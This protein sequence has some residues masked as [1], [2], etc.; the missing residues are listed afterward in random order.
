MHSGGAGALVGPHLRS[1]AGP[2]IGEAPAE[3]GERQGEHHDPERLMEGEGIVV[4]GIVI[5]QADH[6][7]PE[8][9]KADDPERDGPVEADGDKAVSVFSVLPHVRFPGRRNADRPYLRMPSTERKKV[10]G[11]GRPTQVHARAEGPAVES[12]AVPSKPAR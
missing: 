11:F 7:D 5:G 10:H 6:P 1:E 8:P 4:P 2:A 9:G 3:L 12:V